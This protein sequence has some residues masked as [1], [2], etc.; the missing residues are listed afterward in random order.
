MTR[1]F[2]KWPYLRLRL[3]AITGTYEI[4]AFD[5]YSSPAPLLQYKVY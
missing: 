4:I 5:A 3:K 2:V 1:K